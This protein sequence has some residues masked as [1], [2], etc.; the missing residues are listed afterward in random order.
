MWKEVVGGKPSEGCEE[1]C[2]D[3]LV[4]HIK[5]R[6]FSKQV[7]RIDLLLATSIAPI[8]LSPLRFLLLLFSVP[9]LAAVVGVV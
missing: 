4:S 6:Y 5:L 2:E 1:R 7:R 9:Y 8:I 3:C